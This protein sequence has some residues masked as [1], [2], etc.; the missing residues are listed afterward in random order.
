[1]T[2]SEMVNVWN[3]KSLKDGQKW[4]FYPH[5]MR[6]PSCLE[7][8][9]TLGYKQAVVLLGGSDNMITPLWWTGR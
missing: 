7:N 2:C 8:A 6:Y 5:R 9:D 3:T 1:M 4:E